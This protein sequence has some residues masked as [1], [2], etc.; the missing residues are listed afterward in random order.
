MKHRS[1]LLLL[2]LWFALPCS[3]NASNIFE[4]VLVADAGNPADTTGVGAVSYEFYIGAYEVTNAQYVVFLNAVAAVDPHGLWNSEMSSH[5]R[6]GITRS[7]S[8]GSYS[9]SAKPNMGDKPV[10]FVSFWDAARFANWLTNGQ[11]TGAQGT[12]TTEDGMYN[13][14][15]VTKPLNTSV[16][17]QLDFSAGQNGVAITSED[18]WYKAA[19]Y[20]PSPA[21]PP[22]GYWMYPT[23][24]NAVP[25]ATGPNGTN[26]N[27]ANYGNA[28][29]NLTEVGGYSIAD[30]YYGTFD[31][32]GNVWEW[33][34]KLMSSNGRGQ[35]GGDADSSEVFFRSTFGSTISHREIEANDVG[36]RVSSLAPIVIETGGTNLAPTVA[37]GFTVLDAVTG[38]VKFAAVGSSDSDGDIVDYTWTWPGGSANG[39]SPTVILPAGTTVVTLTVTDNHG[40]TSTETITVEVAGAIGTIL[41]DDFDPDYDP[42]VWETFS[43]TVLANTNGQNAGPGSTDNSLWFGGSGERSATTVPVDTTE[44]ETIDFDLALGGAPPSISNV[45]EQV[46]FGEKIYLDASTNGTDFFV[47]GGPYSNIAWE[48]ISI[49][50][51]A[52]AQAP[53]TRFR[54]R[55][56]NH[57]GPPL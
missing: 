45:W 32:A 24:G 34:D 27:S 57:S 11:P 25:A 31:Q 18:E 15:G 2:C 9:Y 30:S 39:F 29:D 37:G 46:D 22:G 17:R 50:L 3:V 41:A 12:G 8:P 4:S 48:R 36:F 28:V 53:S 52:S 19:F 7:G 44:G 6:G 56:N 10:N 23:R 5:I 33:N 14:N 43:G 21:G 38:E 40:A 16:F 49:A 1:S 20:D 47:I 42:T 13:L 26:A 35:R 51:P 54:F 55:Q